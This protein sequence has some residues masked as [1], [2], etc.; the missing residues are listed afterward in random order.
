MARRAHMLQT[1]LIHGM[2]GL[3]FVTNL[4][5]GKLV[6]KSFHVFHVFYDLFLVFF[7]FLSMSNI[8][9]L[10][11]LSLLIVAPACVV[12]RRFLLGMPNLLM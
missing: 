2:L 9:V 7:M 4:V 1:N 5:H 6:R 10:L 8:A 3:M 12:S 11:L